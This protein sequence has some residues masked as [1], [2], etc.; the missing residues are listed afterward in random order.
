MGTTINYILY[1]KI[2]YFVKTKIEPDL[3]LILIKKM[4]N[5]QQKKKRIKNKKK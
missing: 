4:S 5:K 3:H 1:S 2:I